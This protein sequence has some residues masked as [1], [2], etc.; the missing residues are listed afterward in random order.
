MVGNLA[1]EDTLHDVRPVKT[2]HAVG[3][4]HS[5]LPALNAARLRIDQ[6]A[7]SKP[8]L[9]LREKVP[10][11]HQLILH[12]GDKFRQVFPLHV[13]ALAM[14]VEPDVVD[15]RVVDRLN[16]LAHFLANPVLAALL[17]DQVDPVLLLV[18]GLR[19]PHVLQS[20]LVALIEV[21]VHG[22]G[23][24]P[25]HSRLHLPD[26]GYAAADLQMTRNRKAAISLLLGDDVLCFAEVG[27]VALAI[28]PP[29]HK[30]SAHSS[31]VLARNENEA[32]ARVDRL[33]RHEAVDA[34]HAKRSI[35]HINKLFQHLVVERKLVYV[36]DAVG[37]EAEKTVG[38]VGGVLADQ[39]L[40]GDLE[41][42]GQIERIREVE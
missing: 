14:E 7:L 19:F 3:S 32:R 15:V 42:L 10:I 24:R 25:G 20:R 21:G 4:H 27:G 8:Y 37:E 1:R 12:N 36:I 28:E 13:L 2:V 18:V 41:S 38:L 40:H 39:L 17:V 31:R 6:L 9:H 30:S 22:D 11:T 26:H 35:L 33:N 34:G 29:H 5:L 23:W 16:H